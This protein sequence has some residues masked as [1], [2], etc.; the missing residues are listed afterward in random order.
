MLMN[1]NLTAEYPEKQEM[2]ISHLRGAEFPPAELFEGLLPQE[3]DLAL[4]A[5]KL[6]RYRAR[7]VIFRQGESAQYSFV[8]REGR[9]RYFYDTK[10]GKKL[11]L[12]WILPGYSFGLAGML[13][14]MDTYLVGVETT[15]DSLVLAWDARSI[16]ALKQQL[17]R[18]AE[19]ALYITNFL[20][21]WYI[22]A[23]A[24]LCSESAQE[25]LSHILF[26]YA[27]KLGRKV[28]EGFE[29]DAT[30]EELAEAANVTPFTTSRLMSA[31]AKRK[32]L[33]KLRGKILLR[34]PERLFHAVK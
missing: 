19:N 29:V 16:Q 4:S 15:Q 23:Y 10:N 33:Q 28:A 25:R 34:Y 12:R 5:A 22:G 13:R 21:S 30:N 20:F 7:S 14:R 6:R 17:P 26:E 9:A 8:L 24:A 11:I 1:S 3:V 27:T 32:L 2:S 18:L 31:W